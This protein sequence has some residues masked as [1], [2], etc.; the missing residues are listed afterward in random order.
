MGAEVGCNNT[1]TIYLSLSKNSAMRRSF[2]RFECYFSQS[3]QH[4]QI[5]SCILKSGSSKKCL[6]ETLLCKVNIFSRGR[7]R[8]LGVNFDLP[9]IVQKTFM[10][11]FLSLHDI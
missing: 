6:S 10:Y 5:P 7:Q 1:V 8:M 9:I 4:S 2:R 3:L 11:H